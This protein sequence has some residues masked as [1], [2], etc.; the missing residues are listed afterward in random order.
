MF[1]KADEERGPGCTIISKVKGHATQEMIDEGKVQKEDNKGNGQADIGVDRGAVTMQKVT[2]KLADLYS[3]RHGGYRNLM[4]RIQ[5]YIVGLK[6]HDRKLRGE[7]KRQ[8]DPFGKEEKGKVCIP[9]RLGYADPVEETKYLS[10][11]ALH[12]MWFETKAKHIADTKIHSFLANI[13]WRAEEGEEIGGTTWLGLYLLY[14][15]HG[16][17]EEEETEGSFAD[18]TADED[19]VSII[20][21]S[22]AKDRKACE[23]SQ[24]MPSAKVMN[25]I[26]KQTMQES[27][28]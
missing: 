28:G 5:K 13:K 20:Q 15:R 1:A 17:N 21:A 6:N 10:T 14:A 24:S 9:K 25:G 3:W 18:T 7:E 16:G 4:I 2:Q 19:T 23:R 22:H 12:Q 26:C 27:Q 8:D 11:T